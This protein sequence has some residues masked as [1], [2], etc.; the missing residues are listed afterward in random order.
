MGIQ[1]G[2]NKTCFTQDRVFGGQMRA[3]RSHI[4]LF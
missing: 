3:K 2:D 4:T 1:Q